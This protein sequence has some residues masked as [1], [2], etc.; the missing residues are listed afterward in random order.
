MVR[1]EIWD[2]L[3]SFLEHIKVIKND[4]ASSILETIINDWMNQIDE[5]MKEY[6]FDNFSGLIETTENK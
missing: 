4:K 3:L 6:N 2:M 5:K 1:S